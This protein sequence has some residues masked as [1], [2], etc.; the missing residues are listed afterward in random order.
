MNINININSK[1]S[2]FQINNLNEVFDNNK[3]LD[4]IK[5]KLDKKKEK[6]N[7]NS[8]LNFSNPTKISI[9]PHLKYLNDS[10]NQKKS[11][12]FNLNNN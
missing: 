12:C 8:N 10:S 4:I 2:T 11:K 6:S 3:C 5:K 9:P 7:L 1:D